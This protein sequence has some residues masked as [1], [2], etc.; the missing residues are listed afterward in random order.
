MTASASSEN[1]SDPMEEPILSDR[2]HTEMLVSSVRMDLRED[3]GS[4]VV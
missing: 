1:A 3:V 4:V 2:A